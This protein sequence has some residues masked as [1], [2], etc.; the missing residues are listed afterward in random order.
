MKRRSSIALAATAITLTLLALFVTLGRNESAHRVAPGAIDV[1][2]SGSSIALPF[3]RV[4]EGAWAGEPSTDAR[5]PPTAKRI[6]VFV[7]GKAWRFES[8]RVGKESAAN[9]YTRIARQPEDPTNMEAVADFAETMARCR[10]WQQRKRLR[11]I[12]P[13]HAKA[14]KQSMFAA[15]QEAIERD[16][17]LCRGVS[18]DAVTKNDQFLAQAADAG[19]PRARYLYA[20]FTHLSWL[21]DTKAIYGNPELLLQYKA[22]A[23]GYLQELANEGHLESLERL[24]MLYASAEQGGD[25]VLSWAYAA[26]AYK[27][28]NDH[29]AQRD[30]LQRLNNLPEADR[31]RALKEA[32]QI[33]AR[34]C[35]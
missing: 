4:S 17:P 27:A 29:Q 2:G 31:A 32:E 30:M 35:R 1:L 18:A 19:D 9:L 26:A 8:D 15:H 23:F 16:A 14:G 21:A 10:L 3:G 22:K 25:R 28:Q 13:I 5:H 12:E 7:G 24:S 11:V 34:C 20:S 6:P 33:Y